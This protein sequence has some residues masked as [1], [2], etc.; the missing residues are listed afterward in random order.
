M[1]P[2]SAGDGNSLREAERR[3]AEHDAE[4]FGMGFLVNGK[5]IDPTSVVVFN[6]QSPKPIDMVLFCPQCGIQ[7]IDRPAEVKWKDDPNGFTSS[8]QWTNPPHRS[9][10]CHSC[11]HIWRPADVP[12]NGVFTIVTTGNDDTFPAHRV[13]AYNLQF[14]EQLKVLIDTLIA[15][16][17]LAY[18]AEER[19]TWTSSY[20]KK[21]DVCERINIHTNHRNALQ[22]LIKFAQEE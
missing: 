10:L 11:R 8:P 16:Q 15:A 5:R 3:E 2:F 19:E 18:D 14:R 12:T 7:H 9:H 4:V 13:S 6:N 20:K 17:K 21:M 22:A 1:N